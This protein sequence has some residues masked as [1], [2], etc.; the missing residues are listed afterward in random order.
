[1]DGIG[2]EGCCELMP[3][4]EVAF[5]L[6]PCFSLR[7]RHVASHFL[8]E[9][10]PATSSWF[11]FFFFLDLSPSMLS[12]SLALLPTGRARAF[13]L[14]IA[15][16]VRL[17]VFFSGDGCRFCS[18]SCSRSRFRSR[19]RCFLRRR[20]SRWFAFMPWDG[21]L[22]AELPVSGFGVCVSVV[23]VVGFAAAAGTGTAGDTG[24]RGFERGGGGGEWCC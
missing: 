3:K 24:R 18:R 22:E 5:I 12:T 13:G 4:W 11:V 16:S 8:V 1:M 20:R 7:D 15:H 17:P 6:P 14:I 10:G 21:L 19:A 9:L 23:A 2:E